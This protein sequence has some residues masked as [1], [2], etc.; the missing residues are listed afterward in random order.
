MIPPNERYLAR[1]DEII[2]TAIE[3]F[4]S[5]GYDSGSI[6][7]V[8]RS[9][10][11]PGICGDCYEVGPGFAG[12]F[13]PEVLKAGEGDRLLLDL[14][15]ANRR[16]FL[17]TGPSQGRHLPL[18]PLEGPPALQHLRPRDHDRAHPARGSMTASRTPSSGWPR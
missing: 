15:E 5:K 9:D 11:G 3:V 8:A 13:T 6:E 17:A 12:R 4:H 1:W 16:Q 14:V 2:N 10:I 7:D 18:L